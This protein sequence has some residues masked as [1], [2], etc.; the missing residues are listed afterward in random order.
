MP[1]AM[2]S[3]NGFYS[4]STIHQTKPCVCCIQL[5]KHFEFKESKRK[6]K[7]DMVFSKPDDVLNCKFCMYME[8]V[9][10]ID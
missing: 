3:L 4:M 7:S 10:D 8:S 5:K 1:S 9:F 6:E 2:I